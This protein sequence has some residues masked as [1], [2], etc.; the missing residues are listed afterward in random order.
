MICFTENNYFLFI[1]KTHYQTVTRNKNE[2]VLSNPL[3]LLN[4]VGVCIYLVNSLGEILPLTGHC[5]LALREISAKCAA[6][7][8]SLL[9]CFH[10]NRKK[11][12][13]FVIS[14]S[15]DHKMNQLMPRMEEN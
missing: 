6:P 9:F 8:V 11:K 14:I 2:A 5:A 13:F 7:I 15:P 3:H 12:H 10:K 4:C 1:P